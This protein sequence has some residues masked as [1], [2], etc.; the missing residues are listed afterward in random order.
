MRKIRILK[1][2]YLINFPLKQKNMY[3]DY[4]VGAMTDN[5]QSISDILINI[6]TVIDKITSKKFLLIMWVLTISVTITLLFYRAFL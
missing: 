3:F 5:H 2:V 4:T 6:S 1:A